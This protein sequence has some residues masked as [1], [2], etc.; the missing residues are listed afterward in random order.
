LN[1]ISVTMSNNN[2]K[3]YS[4]PYRVIEYHL[5]ELILAVLFMVGAFLFGQQINVLIFIAIIGA[6]FI[7][8]PIIIYV[9][10]R[11]IGVVSKY[12]KDHKKN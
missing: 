9:I 3:I 4:S 10:S 8:L 1:T 7:V 5:A 12:F 6:F 11:I 2:K